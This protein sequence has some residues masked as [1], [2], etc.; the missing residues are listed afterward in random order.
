MKDEKKCY[1]GVMSGTSLDGVDVV[2]CPVGE[3]GIEL[4]AS[5]EYPFDS[6][7]KADVLRLISGACTL[8]EVGG[9]DHRL[10]ILFAD[11]VSALIDRYDLDAER[12]EAIGLHGQTLWHAPSDDMPFTMQLGDPNIVCA[13]TAIRTVADFRR[14]DMALGGQGAPFAPAFH[15]FVFDHLEGKTVVVNIGGIS[16]ITVLDEPLR[17]YDTGRGTC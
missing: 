13:R 11:A 7:L 5:L 17:G 10:G 6:A 3:R 14:K 12:I 4:A 2:L 9:I 1:I 15:R 16:N 8:E